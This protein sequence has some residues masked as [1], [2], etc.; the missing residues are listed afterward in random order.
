MSPTAD[1]YYTPETNRAYVQNFM[2]VCSIYEA[3][4]KQVLA[5][6]LSRAP[7]HSKDVTVSSSFKAPEPKVA[8]VSGS[9][10]S[11]YAGIIELLVCTDLL[12]P[13]YKSNHARL[14]TPI[15]GL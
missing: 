3:D 12:G 13:C 9:I 15:M 10:K 5:Y 1:A 2:R 8:Q 7:S 4:A 11:A 14:G 6:W